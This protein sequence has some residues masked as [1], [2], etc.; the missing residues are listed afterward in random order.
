MG[1]PKIVEKH[2]VSL[3]QTFNSPVSKKPKIKDLAFSPPNTKSNL[4]YMKRENSIRIEQFKRNPVL[5]KKNAQRYIS[6]TKS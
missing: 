5:D 6:T 1:S 2:K 3:T 4:N